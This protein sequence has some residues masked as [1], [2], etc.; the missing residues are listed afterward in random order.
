MEFI[1][2]L[3]HSSGFDSFKLGKFK[4]KT[5]VVFYILN[6]IHLCNQKYFR[7]FTILLLMNSALV[8]SGVKKKKKEK[9]EKRYLRQNR[10]KNVGTILQQFPSLNL[11]FFFLEN[12]G[13]CLNIHAGDTQIK[14]YCELFATF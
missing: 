12:K 6:F 9:K 2:D 3:N 5:I 1:F 14:K 10:K 13:L 8:L 4:T 11:N 7:V